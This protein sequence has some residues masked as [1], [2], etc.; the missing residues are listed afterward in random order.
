MSMV[1][2]SSPDR[3]VTAVLLSC[4]LLGSLLTLEQENQDSNQALRKC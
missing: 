3:V 2:T 1:I 4:G